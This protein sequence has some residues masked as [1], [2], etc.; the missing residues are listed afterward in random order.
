MLHKRTEACIKT[1]TDWFEPVSFYGFF[2]SSPTPGI[3]PRLLPHPHN[4]TKRRY[5]EFIGD[6]DT[7]SYGN[8]GE[9]TDAIAV[10]TMDPAKQNAWNSYAA[11]AAR[12]F[13]ADCSMV[14]WTGIG[15]HGAE[16]IPG[17]ELD[18]MNGGMRTVYNRSVAYASSQPPADHPDLVVVYIGGNDLSGN[19]FGDLSGVD[20]ALG[21]TALEGSP[22]MAGRKVLEDFS[23][24]LVEVLQ[25]VRTRNL[26]APVVLLAP[27]ETTMSAES[28]TEEQAYT[29]GLVQR[30]VRL[31]HVAFSAWCVKNGHEPNA[32]FHV[33]RP[34]PAISN[35]DVDPSE[36][37]LLRH[38]SVK[39]HQKVA[40]ALVKVI[41]EALPEWKAT[42]EPTPCPV[43]EP[44]TYE[45]GDSS[46]LACSL[47]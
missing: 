40:R 17:T 28:T 20:E 45:I 42:S 30:G 37:G 9:I 16:P 8:E 2:V 19:A 11:Q 41:E 34:T 22:G 38:W 25:A 44:D 35:P 3:T 7:T 31:A 33:L 32:S 24:A 23:E 46:A 4:K 36:W 27:N 43:L 12:C 29:A 13:D 5:V 15:V 14:C 26:H 18:V 10:H 1:V 47:M 6:S 39:G 21:G